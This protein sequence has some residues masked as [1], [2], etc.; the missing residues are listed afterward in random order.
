MPTVLGGRITL[1][2][3]P[4]ARLG[5]A[6]ATISISLVD[7]IGGGSRRP[8]QATRSMRAERQFAALS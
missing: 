8:Y 1:A 6:I 3:A 4:K 2:A 5:A 7:D